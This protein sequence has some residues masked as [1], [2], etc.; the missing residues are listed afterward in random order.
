MKKEETAQVGVCTQ[1]RTSNKKKNMLFRIAHGLVLLS[2]RAVLGVN[3]AYEAAQLSAADTASFSAIAFGD[4]SVPSA[5]APAAC[6][7]LPG[8]VA[9]PGAA[10]WA[11]LNSTLGGALLRPAVPASACYRNGE[12]ENGEQENGEQEDSGGGYDAERCRWLLGEGGAG[13]FY[14]DDPVTVLTRWPQGDT[15]PASTPPVAG[16]CTRGGYAYYVINAT[17]VRQ[18]QAAVNFAR[19]R[20]VRLTVKNTGHDFVGKSTGRGA[21]SVWTHNLKSFEFIPSYNVTADDGETLLYSGMAA[22]VGT[23]LESWEMYGFMR[24]HG[25]HLGVPGDSTVA[26]YGGWAQ[27]GGHHNLASRLGL[28][29]DQVLSLQVVTAD[30]RLVTADHVANPDLFWALRGGGPSTY[31]IITSAIV[32]AHAPL[33]VVQSPLRFSTALVNVTNATSAAEK[34]EVFWAGVAATYWFCK[35]VTDAGGTVYDNIR[36]LSPDDGG[37]DFTADFELPGI[38][39]AAA[40]ALVQPLYDE[41]RG[42]GVAVAAT[43]TVRA[44]PRS[45]DASGGRGDRPGN[46]RFASRLFPRANWEDVGVFAAT[47]AAIRRPVE[48][49]YGFHGIHMTPTLAVAGWPGRDSAVNPA[50]RTTQMHADL[51]DRASAAPG[52]GAA[53]WLETWAELNGHMQGIREATPGGGAYVNEADRLEPGWQGSFW[54]DKYERLLAIKRARDPWGLFYAPTTPGS[55]AWEVRTADGLPTQNGRL[56]RVGERA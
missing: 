13:R 8:D 26:P 17:S 51:F 34:A 42:L 1:R 16:N 39:G 24:R 31:G 40:R 48:A 7:A 6:K 28:G 50:F 15:C 33:E 5:S 37:F 14:V 55:E 41:L 43:P 44:S 27:G 49:G 36:R 18:I 23:G 46:T 25:M 4:A 38:T 56:C 2:P 32:K 53:A 29:A 10:E 30:G 35:H 9:W 20:N 12:Q 54:G 52:G 21:L 3:F 45:T 47:V 22:R 19:N 11:R